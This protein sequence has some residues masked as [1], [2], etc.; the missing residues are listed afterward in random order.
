MAAPI[1]QLELRPPPPPCPARP[2]LLTRRVLLVLVLLTPGIPEFLT[3]STSVTRALFDPA[4]FVINV[5]LDVGLY[6]TGALLI[7]EAAARWNRGWATILV[8]GLAYG[9][10]EEGLAVHTFFQSGGSPVGL[11]GSYGRLLGLNTVWATE[12]AFF[13][14]TFSIAIPLLIFDRLYPRLRGVPLLTPRSAA[15]CV[16]GILGVVLLGDA[17]F[18][19]IDRPPLFWA[20]G[21]SAL[22]LA[23]LL[24]AR[25]LPRELLAPVGGPPTASPR[26]LLLVGILPFAGWI[27][28][29]YVL[30]GSHVPA[31]ATLAFV[32]AS[33]L[34]PAAYAVRHLG[35]AENQPH[36]FAF[37]VGLL[38][39]I[40]CWS[41]VFGIL[42]VPGLEVVGV[43][44]IV[45]LLWLRRRRFADPPP[46]GIPPGGQVGETV[47]VPLGASG[48]RV[49]P[50]LPE[51]ARAV[52][53]QNQ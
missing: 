14:A 7:R 39:P 10:V 51:S 24:I 26:Q 22:V 50:P 18:A 43:G 33:Y 1:D 21:L 4:G 29:S 44:Y 12:F 8:L 32:L 49:G 23:L 20:I 28:V 34:L 17:V 46:S 45:F 11:F 41:I 37:L 16:G 3:G 31:A 13:H 47:P 2:D 25:R 52:S 48:G 19:A 5:L 6:T 40:L 36:Q 42:I 35:T 30:A 9:I 15:V 53:A 27:P 38:L